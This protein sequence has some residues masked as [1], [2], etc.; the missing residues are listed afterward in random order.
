MDIAA[1]LR[2]L[3]LEQY[4]QAF[5]DN[6]VDAAV[7]PELT[8][9]DLKGLGVSLVGHRRKLLAA[10]AVL[11]SD[12]GPVTDVPVAASTVERRHLTVMFCDLVGSTPLS[13]R[14]DPEDLRE[15]MAAYH[16]AVAEIV[17][18]FDGFVSRYMGDGV[19]ALFG[20]P[21]AHEDDAERAVRAALGAID[22]VSR[23]DV[24]SVRL[25]TR[26]G[27]ATGLV[28][29]GD[30]IG[31]GSAQEQSVVGE[32]PNLAARLQTLAE[33]NSLVIAADTRRLV[34]DLFEYRDLGFVDMRGITAPVSAWQVLRASGVTSRFEALRGSSPSY[35]IGR[36]EEIELLLR[37]WARARA[38]DGQIVLI[39]G[40]P[41][42]GKSRI[43]AAL[44]ERLRAE[45]HNHVGYFCSPY[46]QDSVLYPF[47][48]QL[49]RA[50]GFERDDTAEQKLG[51]LQGLVAP[52]AQS[53][54]DIALMAELLSLPNC[55]ANLNLGLQRKR[56]QLFEA[57][58]H[59]LEALA[60]NRP[61]IMIF[62]DL[63][64]IDP[65]SRELLDLMLDRVSR[66][67]A[68]VV[69]TFRPE[70][71]HA[72]GDHHHATT[73]VLDRLGKR[74]G[75]VLVEWLAGEAS[76]PREIVDE[77]VER[78]DGVPLFVEEITKAVIET[79]A[80]PAALASIPASLLAVPATLY[81]S[82]LARLDRFSPAVK[83]VA[84][85]AAAIGREFS[86]ELLSASIDQLSA[87][88]LND[89]LRRLV[90][91]GL[92][93]QRGAPPTAAYVF[94]HA[95]VQ[96]TA[97]GTLLRG[98]RRDIHRRIAEVLEAQF[99]DLL[100][101][102]PEIA[103]HHFSEA[104]EVERAVT[105]WRRAGELSVAKS[106]V[107]E[108]MAQLRRGLELV[109]SLPE[110]R[111]RKQLELDLHIALT[112][113]LMGARGYADPEVSAT[114]ERSRQLVTETG[115]LGTPLH[116]SVL[117]GIWVVV[118][119]GGRTE[120]GLHHAAEFLSLAESQLATGPLSIG[121][122]MLAASLMQAGDYRR[123]LAHGKMAASLYRSDEHREFAFR[124]GQD[125]GASALCYLS[126]AW[127]HGGYPDQAVETADRAVRH[128]REFGHAHTLAY[129]LWHIAILAV[130][131]RD[132]AKVERLAK[133]AAAISAEHG[134]PLWS[135]HS[136]I[137]LGWVAARSG[138]AAD[139]ILRMRAA[140]TARMATGA[141]LLEPLFLG[142]IAEGLRLDRRSEESLVLLDEAL[143]VAAETGDLASNALLRWLQGELLQRLG[144][145]NAATAEEA[146]RRAV[147]EARRQG[148]RGYELRAATSLAHL[149]RE[150]GR[151]AEARDLLA[152]VLGWFTEGFDTPD[153]K[154]AKALLNELT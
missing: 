56:E 74:D 81:A 126:W 115:G 23:L 34:G 21:Q 112:A 41:G 131:A 138:Q 10:I 133:E 29:V 135:A 111:D 14:L 11:R 54:D 36:D 51:K 84:Q 104:T 39:S 102:R 109:K 3:G 53:D 153:L 101:V 77:I 59:Q 47:V 4:E 63:H 15:V 73:L 85:I 25:Q 45:P 116:F 121:H 49:E 113:A 117:Y 13:S 37:R 105:Y 127:W 38:G 70:F 132:V 146:L 89:A 24:K 151:R 128:A 90:E 142:L 96:D 69:I 136:E 97:Y 72:W 19:L 120:A 86:H 125:I 66:L 114:L 108:A 124:F 46:H 35:L 64:W 100:E 16:R 48:I 7:L 60:R 91:A 20:Y 57:L 103:A 147:G 76:L 134:F 40:E 52:G 88:E 42:I 71:D 8:A 31:H 80:D 106:A 43:A 30:L 148:S 98:A 94:K 1:W 141:R 93:F 68:L 119:V 107:R 143:A 83:Q 152:P 26:V 28:V 78:A 33:P 6:D 27:I 145:S 139:G 5:R 154:D 44:E 95:L 22:A 50:A 82:L 149:M 17:S 62:E 140:V 130:F 75:A 2:S 61:V 18:G 123:A 32:T 55:S 87:R 58:L 79:G 150:Q 118:Y 99:P 144:T 67:P 65:T 12:V 122:R 129:T 92:L 9:E 137:L 110:S